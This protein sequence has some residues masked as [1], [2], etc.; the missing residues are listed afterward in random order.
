MKTE[1]VDFSKCEYSNR[2]GRY[3]GQAGDKDGILYKGEPWIVK[4]PKSTVSM[5]GNNLP[6]YTTSPLSEYVG[7]HVYQILGFDAHETLLGVRNGKL[8]VACKD[9]QDRL[10]DIAEIRTVKNAAN[11]ELSAYAEDELPMS[12]TG[13]IVVLEELFL[14][15]EV[16]PL[17]HGKEIQ[18][19]FWECVVVDILLNNGDRNN[20]NW[21]LLF[22]EKEN[23]YDV[24]PVY[25]NG[26][27]FNNK[28]SE[29]AI[30][31]FLNE[32]RDDVLLGSPTVYTYGGKRLSAK[33][34]LQLESVG[35]QNAVR[36][37]VPLIA[38]RL[39]AVFHF[40]DEIPEKYN[41]ILVCSAQRKEFY[42]VSMQ[43]RLDKLLKPAYER[44]SC[45]TP[46]V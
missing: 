33:M 2:H 28:S 24:A 46:S 9:F 17:L 36:R 21:G 44:V 41:D 18:E 23:R 26:N 6:S 40:I 7:S 19:R 35:L 31:K 14:H 4:Y 13:D 29:E 3:G 5:K 1:I 42:K 8:V 20:G 15:F 45:G 27:S 10:G 25:D 30:T 22:N 11:K 37:L 38:D 34:L 32:M 43:V 12:A 39:P 16:N